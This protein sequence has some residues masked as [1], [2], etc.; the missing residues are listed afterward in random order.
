MSGPR[1]APVEL[2]LALGDLQLCLQLLFRPG[3]A[4]ALE[5]PR[6]LRIVKQS[7]NSIKLPCEPTVRGL[8]YIWF[9]FAVACL[10]FGLAWSL[11]AYGGPTQSY[12]TDNLCSL[13]RCCCFHRVATA[14]AYVAVLPAGVGA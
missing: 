6:V 1:G 8:P 3:L 5:V 9:W 11:M 10:S 2:D 13:T 7:Y 14:F 4:P 12:P